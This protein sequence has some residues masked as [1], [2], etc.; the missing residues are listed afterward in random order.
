MPAHLPEFMHIDLGKLTGTGWL[1]LLAT[2]GMV[3][4]VVLALVTAVAALGVTISGREN[5]W[6]VVL[7]LVGAFAVG[8]G[9]FALGRRLFAQVGFPIVKPGM[10]RRDR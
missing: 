2:L 9:F 5:R 6:V 1:L 7:I 4:G 8:G 3:G 10:A